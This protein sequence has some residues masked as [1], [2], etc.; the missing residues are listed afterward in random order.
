MINTEFLICAR[1]GNFR[2]RH[3]EQAIF[4]TI[5][6]LQ[7]KNNLFLQMIT[8]DT[9]DGH[10]LIQQNWDRYRLNCICLLPCLSNTTTMTGVTGMIARKLSVTENL[11]GKCLHKN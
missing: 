7:M 10:Q 4:I 6:F 9:Q 11:K 3:Y 2:V 1:L 8:V 5:P